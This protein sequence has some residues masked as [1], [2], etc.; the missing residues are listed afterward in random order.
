MVV[1]VQIYEEEIEEY[2]DQVCEDFTLRLGYR[3]DGTKPLTLS[4]TVSDDETQLMFECYPDRARKIAAKIIE[5]ADKM[6]MGVY[7]GPIKVRCD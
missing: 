3:V 4:I 6:E 5:L 7:G 1:L 2:F